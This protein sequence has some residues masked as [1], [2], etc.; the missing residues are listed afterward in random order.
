[1][2]SVERGGFEPPSVPQEA[3]MTRS[4]RHA[5]PDAPFCLPGQWCETAQPGSI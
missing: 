4:D 2:D 3:A 5:L 1:M